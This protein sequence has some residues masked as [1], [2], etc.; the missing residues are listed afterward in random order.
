MVVT[1][2]GVAPATGLAAGPGVLAGVQDRRGDEPSSRAVKEAGAAR[3]ERSESRALVREVARVGCTVSDLDRS[4]EFF[5][6]VL[7]FRKIDEHEYAG[8]GLERLTGVFASR[9]RTAT[10]ILGD[11]EF[12]L[13][14]YL[15]P[16]G[17]AIPADSRSNDLWF[18]HVAIVVSDMDR[19]YARLRE[20]G[21]GYVSSGPQTL[22]GTIPN[23]AGIS[24]FY[25]KDPDGHV[26]ELIHFPPGKGDPRWQRASDAGD[27]HAA[28]RL[29]LGID[30][31]AI[32]VADTEASLG[33]YRDTLGLRV[34]GGSVNFG[35][36][37][38]HLNG[39]FGCVVRITTLKP[40]RGPAV[41][42]LEYVSP[43]G[44]RGFPADS[45]ACDLWHWQITTRV[46]S[47]A[48]ADRAAA[49]LG[50]SRVSAGVI[51]D[52]PGGPASMIRDPDGHAVVFTASK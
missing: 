17:R 25:F 40:E 44:G 33:F 47:V 38:E 28:Q 42:L 12:E 18:Q 46:G 22:P 34:A 1:L 16:A 19:A 29:F 15:A 14:Q 11:E 3:P 52:A 50:A 9:V 31:T 8:D 7:D 39:V 27:Q 5:T 6:T 13:T 43:S 26:L 10:L 49:E 32:G 23:A 51:E 30:H 20:H 24:A 4:V 41:E 36:E 48:G 2:A 35:T 21:V 37:Q 45:R